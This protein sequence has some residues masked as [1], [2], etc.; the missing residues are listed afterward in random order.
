M[1]TPADE[2]LYASMLT[3]Q[4]I[5][6][7][8]QAYVDGKMDIETYNKLYEFAMNA[9]GRVRK[10]AEILEAEAFRKAAHDHP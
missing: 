8:Q 4:T 9:D 5:G 1:N 6:A 2:A 10:L 3:A 7:I